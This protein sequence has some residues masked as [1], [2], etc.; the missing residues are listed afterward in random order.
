[1]DG[2]SRAKSALEFGLVVALGA[3][4]RELG[5]DVDFFRISWYKAVGESR[6]QSMSMCS[7]LP[8]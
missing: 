7:R 1:M 4:W 8:M 6:P 5:R 3:A 2:R